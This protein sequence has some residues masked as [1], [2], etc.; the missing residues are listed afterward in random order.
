MIATA[1]RLRANA[2]GRYYVTD[3]CDACGICAT[4]APA[5]FAQ[6]WDGTYF[7]VLHQPEGVAE[8]VAVRQ[9]MEACPLECIR[10]DG[11]L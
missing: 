7:A 3:E 2:W 1:E 11:D 4:H 5:N 8:A 9:A 10:D 6:G